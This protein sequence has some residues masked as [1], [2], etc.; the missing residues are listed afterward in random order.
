M[1]LF[2]WLITYAVFGLFSKDLSGQ[3]PTYDIKLQLDTTAQTLAVNAA[4]TIPEGITLPKDTVW[5]HLPFNA[6]TKY[7]AF[8]N[9]QLKFNMTNFHFRRENEYCTTSNFK[10]KDGNQDIPFFY[11]NDDQE[12]VGFL[13][14]SHDHLIFDYTLNLPKA[15][16][17][18][19]YKDRNYWLRNFYP[20]LLKFDG[21]WYF[22]PLTQFVQVS[23]RSAD[24][25]VTLSNPFGEIMSSGELNY[26]GADAK[27][28]AKNVKD[29]A[30][31]LIKNSTKIYR[32]TFKSGDKIIPYNVVHFIKT[33]DKEWKGIDTAIQNAAT[34]WTNY[35]GFYPY[36]SLIFNVQNSCPNCYLASGLLQRQDISS[37]DFD[38]NT[39]ISEI[40]G[41]VWVE[42]QFD[43][44]AKQN[45]WLS[46]GLSEYYFNRNLSQTSTYS[47]KNHSSE[48]LFSN[49]KYLYQAIKERKKMPLNTPINDLSNQQQFANKKGFSC[50]LFQYLQIIVGEEIFDKSVKSFANNQKILTLEKLV[51]ELEINSG[52]KLQSIC[53]I[54]TKSNLNTDYKMLGMDWENN[55]LHI[56]IA[57]E[58]S[59]SLP[60]LLSFTRKDDSVEDFLIS[61][62]NGEKSIPVN[63]KDV[64]NIQ[65]VSIDLQGV[66]PEKNRDNNHYFPNNSGK[67]GP[68]KLK[69]LFTNEDSRYRKLLMM[70]YPAY[71]NNDKFMLG[72]VFSNS[73]FNIIKNLSFAFAPMFS[74]TSKNPL[75]QA[76]VNYNKYLNNKTFDLLTARAGIRSFNMDYNKKFDYFLRYIKID[77]SITLRFRHLPVTNITS[78]LTLKAYFINEEMADTDAS[79]LKGINNIASKIFKLDYDIKKSDVLSTSSLSLSAEQQ[80]FETENYLKLTGTVYQRWMYKPKRNIYFRLFASGFLANTQR[81][82]GSFQNIYSRGSIALIHQGYNDYIYDEYFFSRQNQNQL[83]NDQVSLVNG[84][85]FKT[86]TGSAYAIGLSNNFAASL[87]SS[88]DLPFSKSWFPLRAYFDLGTYSTFNGEKFTNNWMYNGGFSLNFSDI[89][90]IHCPLIYSKDLGNS[91]KE[92]HKTFFSRLSFSINL[93]KLNFW[94]VENPGSD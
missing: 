83:Q 7:S 47:T 52:K 56:K 65:Y 21:Q 42:S 62:F 31:Q 91:Y 88:I 17:G 41:E 15:I 92:G 37:D 29:F 40:F 35:F 23:F 78:A 51:R 55:Q 5:F 60:F 69:N 3:N 9:E 59:L 63:L 16:D 18:L 38:L 80:S 43:I 73:N 33:S 70:L 26:E 64:D 67:F 46:D 84:G 54:Y 94:E 24:F 66:L 85:G 44:N 75:G 1:R 28:K 57:N 39:Y 77:P 49:N 8:A 71:N 72:T 89:V 6:Y 27:I 12:F 53:D 50:V 19:G 86:P 93:H 4:I 48:F 58:D 22:Q 25:N 68:F 34:L 14:G 79:G 74:F 13:A 36:S 11:K 90:A 20:Q 61:G 82:S 81:E 30:L 32:G 76:W 45:Y 87:N 2:G 10:I